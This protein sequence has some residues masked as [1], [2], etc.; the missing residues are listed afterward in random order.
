MCRLFAMHAG[1]HPVK[2]TFWLLTAPDSLAEQSRREADGFGIGV[3]DREGR[4]SVVKAP[5]AAYEDKAFAAEARDVESI[6]FIAH[7]RYA[8]TGGDVKTN[9][10]P[11][12][13]DNRLFAHNGVV[14]DLDL[15]DSRLQQMGVM[16]LVKGDTDSER[17]FA[18]ITAEVRS[19]GGDVSAAIASAV[20]WIAENLRLFAVNIILA[21]AANV[22]AVRYP[23]TH[24]LYVLELAGEETTGGM[25][26]HRISMHSA[27]LDAERRPAVLL[28]TEKVDDNP[29]W[30]MMDS[31]EILHIGPSLKVDSS[32]PLPA[33]PRH[34]L[35]LADLSDRAATSQ[36]PQGA[37][38]LP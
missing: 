15:L 26:T 13:Q 4:P 11:F 1:D 7:V 37:G 28:A 16:D 18:L 9:T 30:R 5:I 8:S 35:T 29:N 34:P 10:H 3:Y 14:E 23:D 25:K 27:Q 6:T 20:G 21:D 12:E 19:N 22:W 36:R 24:P 2:A 32:H 33:A 17:V 38:T 31:G